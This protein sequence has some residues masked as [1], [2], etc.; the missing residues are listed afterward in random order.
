M[1]LLLRK[2]GGKMGEKL[3][4]FQPLFASPRGEEGETSSSAERESWLLL[5]PHIH[6]YKVA[7]AHTHTHTCRVQKY[8]CRSKLYTTRRLRFLGEVCTSPLLPH[9][10]RGW[11]VNNWPASRER[12]ILEVLLE[13][14]LGN[15]FPPFIFLTGESQSSHK[16]SFRMKRWNR[17][18]SGNLGIKMQFSNWQQTLKKDILYELTQVLFQVRI[19]ILNYC[20]NFSS[21]FFCSFTLVHLF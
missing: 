11:A 21:V 12:D 2:K 9:F 7:N 3:S 19:R 20:E 15:L 16:I 14:S 4:L 6:T 8:I 10:P 5:L 18:R 1:A 13:R 17:V